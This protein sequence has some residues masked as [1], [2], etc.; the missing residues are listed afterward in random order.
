MR[1]V[2]LLAA[3]CF[4]MGGCLTKEQVQTVRDQAAQTIDEAEALLE[5]L[6]QERDEAL[7]RS[8][9]LEG[10]LAESYATAATV[11]SEK[12]AKVETVLADSRRVVSETDRILAEWDDG[13]MYGP[14]GEIADAV[15][16]FLPPGT[17]VPA[18]LGVGLVGAVQRWITRDRALKRVVRSID[19]GKAESAH[20]AEGIREASETIKAIQGPTTRAIVDRIRRQG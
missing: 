10:A 8:R 11:L 12:I 19:A 4:L 18:I 7:K 14:I 5:S 2:I 13:E 1:S 6:R 16:P 17:Q 3:A 9:E 20:L 15:L